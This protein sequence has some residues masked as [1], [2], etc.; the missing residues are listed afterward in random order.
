MTGW[1][2][3]NSERRLLRRIWSRLAVLL[4]LGAAGV[5]ASAQQ[6][7]SPN[8]TTVAGGGPTAIPAIN[9]GINNIAS[10]GEVGQIAWD[11]THGVFYFTSS[12]FNRVYKYDPAAG[13]ATAIAGTG[14]TG[15]SGDG[16]SALQATF[17]GPLGLVLD[18]TN[19]NLLYVADT[20]NNRVRRID[21]SAN[22]V[23]TISGDGSCI[24]AQLTYTDVPVASAN[25]CA[26]GEMAIDANGT[27][28]VFDLT[29]SVVWRF[30]GG[31]ARMIAG[32]GTAT[33]LVP[34]LP[35]P[36]V[37]TP[38]GNF[39]YLAADPAGQFLYL[40]ET[41]G[42]RQL[43]LATGVLS[44]P[45]DVPVTTPF[46][47]QNGNPTGS[48][49]A[50]LRDGSP[51]AIDP[52]SG[53][54]IYAI[55]ESGAPSESLFSYNL[56]AGQKT[57]IA[58]KGSTLPAFLSPTSDVNLGAMNNGLGEIVA[59]TPTGGSA[60]TFVASRS[61]WIHSMNSL[62]LGAN[63]TTILGNGFRS[64]C[65]DGGPAISACL[66]SPSSVSANPD[67]SFFIAD[68]G[69]S[70]VRFVDTNGIIHSLVSPKAA[71]APPTSI[72]VIPSGVTVLNPI[73]G[74]P[75][76]PGA[77]L[78]TSVA[79][80]QVF[81]LDPAT[82]TT[83]LYS[84]TG[85]DACI[86]FKFQGF[87]D[88]QE[89]SGLDQ[90]HYNQPRGLVIDAVGNPFLAEPLAD[91]IACL[92]CTDSIVHIVGID[93]QSDQQI[94]N[95]GNVDALAVDVGNGLLI[96]EK[97]ANKIQQIAA[98][99]H[100]GYVT[101]F[102]PHAQYVTDVL[103]YR[104]LPLP[105]VTL[106]SPVGVTRIPGQ[107]VA[108]DDYTRIVWSATRPPNFGVCPQG[109]TCI[110]PPPPPQ[111]VGFFAGG[112]TLYQDN[113]PGYQAAFGF[114]QVEAGVFDTQDAFGELTSSQAN[115]HSLVYITDRSDNRI[116]VVDGGTNHSP[117][118]NAGTDRNVP[119]DSGSTWAT[120]LLDG[121]ASTDPDGDA[122]SYSWSEGGSPVGT[123]AFVQ[124]YLGL[125]K[126]AI[127]LAVADGFGGTSSATVNLNVTVPVDLAI[128]AAA[129]P[130]H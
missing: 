63:F 124:D 75:F 23:D 25:V 92:L 114:R 113:V 78:F 91:E 26:P 19:S 58:G 99:P 13:Q 8:I 3:N 108:A 93:P 11:G 30:A 54:I 5:S 46:L 80:R 130:R 12:T 41:I 17:A 66:D 106:F 28:Y 94:V 112:G 18:P 22:T 45:L 29:R 6:P 71:G 97:G 73:S 70:V 60:G 47:D 129:S 31:Q 72:A 51:L 52:A 123:G 120:V 15:F 32:T 83:T 84:G 1:L 55:Y 38:L 14:F 96:A 53:N 49:M 82:D 109:S 103:D 7:S 126:H 95:F 39:G 100:Q 34:T 86:F 50:V 33:D 35:G 20:G 102:Y 110:G 111:Q 21:L 67:G 125:G 117:V 48:Q 36:A 37:S 104:Q 10:T 77:M 115:G 24:A 43:N 107:I 79:A 98:D 2:V 62:T 56:A 68:T 61:G 9:G 64:F 121:S 4:V 16:G 87:C 76:P 128:A 74:L 122:L 118:A 90:A 40:N 44:A 57:F 69:N 85:A 81:A 127:T 27:L 65:G 101:A 59:I 116:R 88:L 119:L 89:D 105:D 42:L